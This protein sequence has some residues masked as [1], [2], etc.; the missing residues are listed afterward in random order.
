MHNQKTSL[1]T[2]GSKGI[3]LGVVGMLVRKGH[4]VIASYARDEEAAER[5]KKELG[6]MVEFV[7][8][9]HAIRQDTYRFIESVKNFSPKLDCIICNAGH[10][11]R[12]NFEETQDKDWDDIFE[13]SLN[14]HL[15]ITRELFPIIS[16]G[17]RI[18]FTGSSMGQWPHATVL[19]YGVAKHAVHALAKNL[20]K[21]FEEKRVTVN[22]VAPGFVDTDWHRFKPDSIKDSILSKTAAHRF[23][24]IEE[25]VKAYEFCVDNEFVNGSVIEVNGGYNY[26]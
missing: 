1:V 10:S 18:I 23:A 15:I 2:G 8:A 19:G 11:V 9:D 13:V 3:G 20:V 14:S 7:K 5:A 21:V 4:R 24:D 17:G 26:K 25:I 12:K 6:G 22:A 16:D